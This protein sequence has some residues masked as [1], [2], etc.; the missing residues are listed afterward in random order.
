MAASSAGRWV[1]GD[2]PN[3]D[4]ART[5]RVRVVP[6][7]AAGRARLSRMTEK[8]ALLVTAAEEP[9]RHLPI[10]PWGFAVLALCVFVILLVVT[11]AFRSS[12]TKH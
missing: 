10:P 8:L 1:A 4:T 7:G 2:E 5:R 12:G 3:Q 9:K 11:F 6:S